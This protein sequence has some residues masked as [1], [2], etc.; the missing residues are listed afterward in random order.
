MYRL[1]VE[2]SESGVLLDQEVEAFSIVYRTSEDSTDMARSRNRGYN[3][4]ELIGLHT[5][6]LEWLRD[7]SHEGDEEPEPLRDS[8]EED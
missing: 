5:W 8:E 2:S 1:L 4:Y 7:F 3:M 6:Y